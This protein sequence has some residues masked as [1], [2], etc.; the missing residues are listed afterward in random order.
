ME[1]WT[2]RPSLQSSWPC[3]ED[4]RLL[5]EGVGDDGDSDGD[6]DIGAMRALGVSGLTSSSSSLTIIMGSS[7]MGASVNSRLARR[8][9][10]VRVTNG[11]VRHAR[12]GH[13]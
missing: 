3:V 10:D 5:V 13:S 9:L 1:M 2:M 8:I 4:P 7:A 6:E 12:R 11:S